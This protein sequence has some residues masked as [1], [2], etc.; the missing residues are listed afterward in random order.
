MGHHFPNTVGVKITGRDEE[1][2]GILPGLH[3]DGTAR[4][5]LS[6][7]TVCTTGRAR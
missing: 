2:D 5:R 1:V 4:V 6:R 3:D 7:C